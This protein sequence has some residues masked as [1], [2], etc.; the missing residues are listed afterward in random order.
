MEARPKKEK[1]K[2][3]EKIKITCVR[4]IEGLYTLSIVNWKYLQI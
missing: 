1:A 4:H 3:I 2:C